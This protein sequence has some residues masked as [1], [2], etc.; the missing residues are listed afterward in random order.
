MV[1]V[2]IHLGVSHGHILSNFPAV[3]ICILFLVVQL[4]VDILVD[5]VNHLAAGNYPSECV[6]VCGSVILQHDKLVKKGTDNK[7]CCVLER[8]IALWLEDKFD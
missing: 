2:G 8:Q 6:L 3:I 7:F 1:V 5:D 4:Y